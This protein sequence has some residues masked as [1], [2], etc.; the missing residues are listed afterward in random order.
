MQ[1][2]AKVNENSFFLYL[3]EVLFKCDNF[4]MFIFLLRER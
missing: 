4:F 2:G 3:E 1:L